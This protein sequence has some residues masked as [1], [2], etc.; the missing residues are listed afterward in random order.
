MIAGS[1]PPFLFTKKILYGRQF[2]Y[3]PRFDGKVFVIF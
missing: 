1:M 2:L 3:T